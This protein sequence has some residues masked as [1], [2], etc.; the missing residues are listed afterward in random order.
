MLNINMDED[1]EM[2]RFKKLA[3]EICYEFDYDSDTQEFAQDLIADWAVDPQSRNGIILQI[4]AS[5]EFGAELSE[6][7][8]EIA[9]KSGVELGGSD[10]ASNVLRYAFDATSQYPVTV[11]RATDTD[12]RNALESWT[13]DRAIAEF[14][15]N[16]NGCGRVD[17]MVA[18]KYISF[19]CGFGL[20]CAKEIVVINS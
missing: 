9:L 17:E 14:Y 20:E 19:Q 2:E 15:V 12:S 11:Y 8:K 4:A 3:R 5:V 7:T 10:V 16:R 18:T 1:R 13:T 6:Y